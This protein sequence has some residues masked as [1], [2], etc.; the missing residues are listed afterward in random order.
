MVELG[1]M[2]K[3][4]AAAVPGIY[5]YQLHYPKPPWAERPTIRPRT[6]QMGANWC[7]WSRSTWSSA[8]AAA[9]CAHVVLR[10]LERTGHH[11]LARHARRSTSSST[12]MLLPVCAPRC[13]VPWSA[14]RRPLGRRRESPGLPRR[15]PQ[16]LSQR[17]ERRQRQAHPAGLHLLS[18]Q[19]T[20]RS[21]STAMC[22]WASPTSCSAA[23]T[24][25]A[26]RRPLSEVRRL[27]IILSEADPEGCAACSMK[28][29][30]ANAYRNGTLYPAIRRRPSRA[31]S[32]CGRC[33]RSTCSPCCPGPSSSR[34][35]TTSRAFARS[36]PTASTSPS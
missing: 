12:T 17:Q 5:R 33:R 13:P 19:G 20:G 16:P 24:G 3:D 2:P 26:D 34:T 22:A 25:F 27:P 31:C 23:E 15:F 8:T 6:T 7:A 18:R 30:P 32:S 36:R 14:D 10:G 28:V 35:G 29:N 11:L 9:K 21:W 4:L 1:F